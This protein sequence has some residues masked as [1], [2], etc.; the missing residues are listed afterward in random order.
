MDIHR[1]I[2]NTKRKCPGCRVKIEGLQ[3]GSN[4]D[5][6]KYICGPCQET[7]WEDVRYCDPD[8]FGA[9]N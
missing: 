2:T 6:H 7:W 5:W 3:E 9:H 8:A 4:K 1:V